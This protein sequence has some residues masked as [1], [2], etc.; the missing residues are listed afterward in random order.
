M[1]KE[2]SSIAIQN[3]D[4]AIAVF[5]P[6]IGTFGA[7]DDDGIDNLLELRVE[8]GNDTAVSE[9]R[10]MI[11]SEALGAAGLLVVDADEFLEVTFL[12]WVQAAGFAALQRLEWSECRFCRLILNSNRSR[13][14]WSGSGSSLLDRC[15]SRNRPGNA[16]YSWRQRWDFSGRLL[17]KLL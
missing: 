10:A 6:E 17:H 1:A 12:D 3:I 15:G 4:V 7:V 8:A 14:G 16:S 11:L 5:V 2:N 13:Y 9:D